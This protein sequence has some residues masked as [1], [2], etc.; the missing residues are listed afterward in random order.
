MLLSVYG[1]HFVLAY[2]EVNVDIFVEGE[3]VDILWQCVVHVAGVDLTHYIHYVSVCV[4]T[5]QVCN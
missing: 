4:H 5:V 3:G 2:L 1:I